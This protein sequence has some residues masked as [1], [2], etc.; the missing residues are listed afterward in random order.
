[1]LKKIIFYQIFVMQ[2]HDFGLNSHINFSNKH[3]LLS[4]HVKKIKISTLNL[5]IEMTFFSSYF[6]L[7]AFKIV[8]PNALYFAIYFKNIDY[9][10]EIAILLTCL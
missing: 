8:M 10:C 4:K 3:P 7:S 9:S 5:L 1:M 6:K 2:N